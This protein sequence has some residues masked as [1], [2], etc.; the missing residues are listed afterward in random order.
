MPTEP[1]DFPGIT[2]KPLSSFRHPRTITI[3][4]RGTSFPKAGVSDIV[5]NPIVSGMM[6]KLG[7][8]SCNVPLEIL[9]LADMENDRAPNT[10]KVCVVIKPF[11][12]RRCE[13]NLFA[14]L[15]QIVLEGMS[16]SIQKVQRR[17][18]RS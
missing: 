12:D 7:L 10:R 9:Y 1:F 14:G 13:S 16:I 4:I 6:A 5:N 8:R 3:E 2:L 17:M 18:Q 11:S 15:E